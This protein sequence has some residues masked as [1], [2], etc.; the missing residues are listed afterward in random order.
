[1]YANVDWLLGFEVAEGKTAKGGAAKCCTASSGKRP[2]H[3]L[4]RYRTLR[5]EN[6]IA[7]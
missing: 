6:R 2:S 3:D 4:P 5:R 1:M 7:P